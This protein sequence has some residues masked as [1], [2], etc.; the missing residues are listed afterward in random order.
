MS[1]QQFDVG[2]FDAYNYMVHPQPSYYVLNWGMQYLWF[3]LLQVGG[4]Y[5]QDKEASAEGK[6]NPELGHGIEVEL[7]CREFKN[8]LICK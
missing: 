1:G 2:S 4:C 7:G 8:T 6:Q 5:P 3:G